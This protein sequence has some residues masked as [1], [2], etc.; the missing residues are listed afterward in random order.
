[1][2][3]LAGLSSVMIIAV[4]LDRCGGVKGYTVVDNVGKVT[5]M[6]LVRMPDARRRA[7]LI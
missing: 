3:S 2:D 7:G 1:M 4:N 6:T 5:I